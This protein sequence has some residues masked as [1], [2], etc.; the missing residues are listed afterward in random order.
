LV[1]DLDVLCPDA[2]PILSNRLD[3]D[4][5]PGFLI[6]IGSGFNNFVDPD[7]DWGSGSIL[8]IRVPDP[9][10]RIELVV[11]FFIFITER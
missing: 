3:P 5:R 7:S 8:G 2:D 4:P 6:R 11:I 1:A 10:V 9:E